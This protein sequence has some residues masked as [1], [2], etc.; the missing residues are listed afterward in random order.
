MILGS[1]VIDEALPYVV[2]M[3][4]EELLNMMESFVAFV[5]VELVYYWC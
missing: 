5:Y 4:H 2:V 3:V 1:V